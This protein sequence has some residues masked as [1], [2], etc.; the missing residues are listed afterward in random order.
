MTSSHVQVGPVSSCPVKRSHAQVRRVNKEQNKH[1][2]NHY[3]FEY[4]QRK[5]V[6]VNYTNV[7]HNIVAINMLKERGKENCNICHYERK[8]CLK[9]KSCLCPNMKYQY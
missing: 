9:I 6:K 3:L 4:D 8:M 2:H 1:N 5:V 7:E